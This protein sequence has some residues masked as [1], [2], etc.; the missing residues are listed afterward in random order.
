MLT[1]LGINNFFDTYADFPDSF[2]GCCP[3]L[4][5]SVLYHLPTLQQWWPEPNHPVWQ[6]KMFIKFSMPQLSLLRQHIVTGTFYD[7][8]S[9]LT[10]TGVPN[11]VRIHA[12][13]DS[14]E[15]RLINF[16]HQLQNQ[17]SQMNEKFEAL[18]EKISS[19]LSEN[20]NIENQ[21]MGR[22]DF[23][24]F[25]TNI[26][27]SFEQYVNRAL[28]HNASTAERSNEQIVN[29][30]GTRDPN[31]YYWGGRF[32]MIPQDFNFPTCAAQN[33]WTQ[34]HLGIAS[35][36]ISPLKKI[37]SHYITDVPKGKRYLVHK[38]K[39]VMDSVEKIARVN[40]KLRADQVID[41]TNCWEIW[42]FAF[43]EYLKLLYSAEQLAKP[44]FRP[45]DI[46]YT[47]LHKIHTKKTIINI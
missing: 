42:K 12:R 30:S 4:L 29:N 1:S 31:I 24:E 3:Y 41:S 17:N 25:Q 46:Y 10:A 8:E 5:A 40:G 37:Y 2:K 39:F 28:S 26:Q 43:G 21:Q 7:P 22:R 47:T 14:I 15:E 13:F 6:S 18:P 44:S 32:H 27:A 45:D 38:A 19:E 20:F 9:Q 33:M 35:Q 23:I 11:I 16:E 34:W 36:N